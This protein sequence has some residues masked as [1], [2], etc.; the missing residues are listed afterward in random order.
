[1]NKAKPRGIGAL[2]LAL[3]GILQSGDAR[4]HTTVAAHAPTGL[5]FGENIAGMHRTAVT[6]VG[7]GGHH[8]VVAYNGSNGSR[9]EIAVFPLTS[10]PCARS[11]QSEANR[12]L[13]EVRSAGDEPQIEELDELPSI[14]PGLG[15]LVSSDSGSLRGVFVFHVGEW[16]LD[17]RTSGIAAPAEFVDELVAVLDWPDLGEPRTSALSTADVYPSPSHWICLGVEPDFARRVPDW[18]VRVGLDD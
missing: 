12:I 9:G 6:E 16:I 10:I 18:R 2:V 13:T 1:M 7:S 17:I 5:Q 15:F 3:V 11:L 8:L 4:A 14:G